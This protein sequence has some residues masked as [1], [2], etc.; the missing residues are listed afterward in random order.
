LIDAS[1]SPF[2][3]FVTLR[4]RRADSAL[5]G[6]QASVEALEKI[7]LNLDTKGLGLLVHFLTSV[8]QCLYREGNLAWSDDAFR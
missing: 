4:R 3:L 8:G 2:D 5:L 1:P 7:D 6:V